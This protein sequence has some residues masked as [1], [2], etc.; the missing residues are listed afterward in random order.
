[1]LKIGTIGF[2]QHFGLSISQKQMQTSCFQIPEIEIKDGNILVK[3]LNIDIN[4][5]AGISKINKWVNYIIFTKN[6]RELFC[7][8]LIQYASAIWSFPQ[9]FYHK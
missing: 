6:L 9:S 3:R 1:M 8:G 7:H 2:L 5:A 4:S